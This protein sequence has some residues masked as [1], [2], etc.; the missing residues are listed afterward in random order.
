MNGRFRNSVRTRFVAL[1]SVLVLL[2]TTM[3]AL[4]AGATTTPSSTSPTSSTN[5]I[6]RKISVEGNKKVPTADIE[7][8]VK[9][10]KVGEPA[11]ET[12]VRS[13]LESI[14][15]LG[16]FYDVRARFA[17]A[18]GG[19]E[20]VFTVVEN[21]AIKKITIDGGGVLPGDQLV[22]ELGL[23]EGDLFNTTT[24]RNGLQAVLKKAYESYGILARV[25][26][27]N[28]TPDGVIS[29]VLSPAKIGK[30]TI[31]G[32]KKT[33]EY[34]IRRELT[35]LK[36]GDVFDLNKLKENLRNV[37]NLGF[38]DEVT[39]KFVETADPDVVDL[40][41][42]VKERTTGQAGLGGGYSTN[43]GFIGYID[44]SEDNFLGFGQ[45]VGVRW[46]FGKSKN[47]YDLSFY[48]PY[49]DS[50]H[51]SIGANLYK[52]STEQEYKPETGNAFK[53][54]EDSFGGALS[55]GRNLG[56][57]LKGSI[58]LKAE[59]VKNTSKD[60]TVTLPPD[61]NTR[62]VAL[63]LTHDTRDFILQPTSGGKEEL[64]AEVA[65]KV[66]G[67][68]FSFQKYQGELT[69]YIKAGDKGSVLAFRLQ[70]GLINGDA[71]SN[72]DFRIGGSE[73]V[74]GYK[75]GEFSGQ[76]MLVMNTEFRFPLVK[77]LQGV[78]FAD[79]GRAWKR[80]EAVDLNSLAP[81]IGVGVR[82]DVPVIGVMRI[83]YGV[84]RDGGKPFLSIGQ[85]F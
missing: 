74:R 39:P 53:Y 55:L 26:D 13:D 23:K 40:T 35:A 51:T 37:L 7:A 12:D 64:S 6:V 67:G 76:K 85:M 38:F 72:A 82:I 70:T 61:G 41:I 24:F 71:P 33:K 73:S 14:A 3:P 65:G 9:S 8:Q 11:S 32:N 83:D 42:E 81:A 10:T 84:G 58:R 77:S 47:T 52:R 1:C 79:F 44:V 43:D 19:V 16:Y 69:R 22:S 56:K 2:G 68:D 5:P 78:L 45:K 25:K 46:E 18:L 49:L 66:F 29:V 59:N 4:A 50:H 15:S 20:V 75:Y 30:I 54:N 62:S 34:V 27:F 21:P 17:E 57:D 63:T 28:I 36:T 80:D 60:T 48:E 31:S